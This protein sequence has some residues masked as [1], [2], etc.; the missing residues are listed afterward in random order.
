MTTSEPAGK[1]AGLQA[2]HRAPPPGTGRQPADSRDA[3]RPPDDVQELRAEIN[4][5]REQL[6]ETVEQLAA[7]ADV[8]ARARD[9]AAELTDRVTGKASHAGAQAAATAGKIRDQLAGTAAFTGQKAMTV[10]TA[11]KDQ[12]SGRVMAAATPVREATPEQVRQAVAK[13]GSTARRRRAPL[14]VAAGVLVFCYLAIR[15]WRRR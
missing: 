13:A 15:R 9:K 4:Q 11:S 10:A 8:K 14:A 12:L 5:T 1:H 2:A 3:T 7:K 6:G